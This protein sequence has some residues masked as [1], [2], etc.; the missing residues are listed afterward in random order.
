MNWRQL[1]QLGLCVVISAPLVLG[2]QALF[3]E[4][5]GERI[6]P[7]CSLLGNLVFW[8]FSLGI[9]RQLPKRLSLKQTLLEGVGLGLLTACVNFLLLCGAMWIWLAFFFAS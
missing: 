5:L 8:S 3:I 1:K 7:L 6:H 9:C 2:S 4:F